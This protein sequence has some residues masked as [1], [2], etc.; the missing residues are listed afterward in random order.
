MRKETTPAGETVYVCSDEKFGHSTI[1]HETAATFVILKNL[2][3]LGPIENLSGHATFD[4]LSRIKGSTGE[5]FTG[6]NVSTVLGSL[7][8]KKVLKRRVNGKRCYYISLNEGIVPKSWWERLNPSKNVR[9]LK[10]VE[11]PVEAHPVHQDAVTMDQV[12]DHAVV[13]LQMLRL[14]L[15]SQPVVQASDNAELDALKAE[16]V[17]LK[18]ELNRISRG[19]RS[20]ASTVVGIVP[21]PRLEKGELNMRSLGVKDARMRVLI[22]HAHSHGFQVEKTNGEHIRFTPPDKTKQLVHTSSTPSDYRAYDNVYAELVRQG[23]PKLEK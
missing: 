12:L 10:Q 15:R 17:R 3:L 22:R 2:F 9:P 6:P 14:A 16:N 19:V 18:D 11:T 13:T 1:L 8:V 23:M 7:D 4:L 21:A 5:E 20:A